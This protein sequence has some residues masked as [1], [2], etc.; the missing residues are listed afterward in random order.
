MLYFIWLYFNCRT[1]Q[2]GYAAINL[3]ICFEY[4]QNPHLNQATQKNLPNFPTQKIPRIQNLKPQKILWS[5]LLLEIQ[6]Q[7]R[8]YLYH[9]SQLTFKKWLSYYCFLD[10]SQSLIKFAQF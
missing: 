7:G 6:I 3:Q 4:L 1:T 8:L 9:V 2:P 10:K 5:S